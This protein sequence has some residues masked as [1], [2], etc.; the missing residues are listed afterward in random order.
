M[1][2][3]TQTPAP[4]ASRRGR[5]TALDMVRTLGVVFLL[6]IPLWFF[7][8]ASPGDSKAI[9]AI[10]PTEALRAFATDTGAP[11]AST[12]AGWT[13]N[14]ATYDGAVVRVGF[15]EGDSYAEFT[16]GTGPTF[17]EMYAGKGSADGTVDVGGASWQRYTSTDGHGSLLRQVGGQTLLI[18]GIRETATEAQLV[19]IAATVR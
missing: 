15:V 4:K 19:E 10:D 7:G 9:R 11:V 14:V 6:V 12:P 17:L 13:P 8:Q 1:T 5:E 16:G 3:P 18:G 2:A